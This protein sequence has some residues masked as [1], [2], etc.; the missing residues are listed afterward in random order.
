MYRNLYYIQ[1]NL[2][3]FIILFIIVFGYLKK[4]REKTS[5]IIF[6]KLCI[7]TMF[8]CILDLLFGI[9][10]GLFFNHSKFYIELFYSLNLEI[11]II[12]CYLWLKYVFTKLDVFKN[13]LIYIIPLIIISFVILTNHLTHFLFSIDENNL[14][15]YSFGMIIYFIVT[16]FYLIIPII[17][18]VYCI[19]KNRNLIVDKRLI[20]LSLFV[21]PLIITNILKYLIPGIT[22]NQVGVTIVILLVFL[23][24]KRNQMIMDELTN[25]YNRRELNRYL[26]NLIV[27]KKNKDI[28]YLMMIDI[29]NFKK[30][31]DNYGHIMGDK[32]LVD[33]ANSLKISC[34]KIGKDLF[35]AR[36]GGDEFIILGVNLSEK[37]I[38]SLEKSI[39]S[40]LNKLNKEATNPFVLDASIGFVSEYKENIKSITAFISEADEKMYQQKKINHSKI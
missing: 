19:I 10:F 2:I 3:C 14:Y 11:E 39:K 5:S 7:A 15:I 26:N 37:K 30:I 34:N 25:L 9:S 20:S 32:A 27:S 23:N 6:K 31:N 21:I 22:I 18:I 38:N 12:I 4:E 40:E 35:I 33:V 1:T 13:L 36:Y 17:K 16:C 28:V 29:N 24:D 8:F